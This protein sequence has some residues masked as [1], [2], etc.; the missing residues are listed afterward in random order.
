[1]DYIAELRER[2]VFTPLKGKAAYLTDWQKSPKSRGE[3]PDGENVGLLLE[4]AELTDV[5]LDSL[6]A[7]WTGRVFLPTDT[8]AAGRGGKIRRYLYEG[9]P[10]LEEMNEQEA[11]RFL[12]ELFSN[13]SAQKEY[14]LR[15][16]DYVMEMPQ[17]G[18]FIRGRD[19]MREFQEAYPTPPSIQ[20][21]RVL[22][23]D[24]LWVVEGVND[25]GGGQVFHVVLLIE[26]REGKMWR[27]RRYY[28]EP[29][30]APEW[31]AQWV[32][33]MEA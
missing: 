8:L 33:R 12:V 9:A 14:E 6:E 26:L 28:A 19:K 15:H 11:H 31:R 22:V 23:R 20:L 10:N 1:M 3:I 4:H 32:E 16:Q 5:A 25:Y 17:S 21:R 13:L 29:F 30:E 7:Q 18:E 27:D 24:G 2:T